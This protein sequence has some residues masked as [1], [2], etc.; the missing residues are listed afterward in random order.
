M[1]RQGVSTESI[2]ALYEA[3][4]FPAL[5]APAAQSALVRLVERQGHAALVTDVLAD[6]GADEASL[7]ARAG[8][9]AF[10]RMVYQEHTSVEEV[11][12]HFYPEDFKPLSWEQKEAHEVYIL[13]SLYYRPIFIYINSFTFLIQAYELS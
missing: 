13:L 7:A 1:V 8:F 10:L 11:I 3:R 9:T 4:V 12:A 2:E 5:R 6:E